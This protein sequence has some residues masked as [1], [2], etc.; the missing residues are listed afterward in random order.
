MKCHYVYDTIAG[1]VLIPGC[2]GVAN[3]DSVEFCTCETSYIMSFKEFERKEY[4]EEVKKLRDEIKRL[5]KDNFSLWRIIKR[6]GGIDF[7]KEFK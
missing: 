5:E 1:K 3:G 2:W 7:K 6:L 4:N